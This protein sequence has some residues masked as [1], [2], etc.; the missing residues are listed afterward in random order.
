[1]ANRCSGC[2]KFATLEFQEPEEE[3]FEIENLEHVL[4]DG[5]VAGNV[6]ATVQISRNS[7][8]CGETM[9]E[10]SLEMSEEFTISHDKLEDHLVEKEGGGWTWKEGCELTA[11]CD[12]PEQV[13]EGGKKPRFGASLAYRV[14]C[15]CGKGDELHE[16]TLEETI[17]GSDMDEAC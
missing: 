17:A 5:T 14:T 16:G 4:E 1:M 15:E 2:N 11:A 10:T 8:C 7:E 12:D 13:E 6:H 3:S 9:R